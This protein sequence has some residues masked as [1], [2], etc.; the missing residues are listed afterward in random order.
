M[1]TASEKRREKDKVVLGL[2]VPASLSYF[3]FV[4]YAEL[5]LLETLWKKDKRD[6]TAS[7]LRQLPIF[8]ACFDEL[9]SYL[10]SV[11]PLGFRVGF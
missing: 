5:S 11:V 1:L 10:I 9:T 4:F 2:T 3:L 8:P 6:L 7:C